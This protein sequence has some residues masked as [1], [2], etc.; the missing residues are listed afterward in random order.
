MIDLVKSRISAKWV[1]G[2]WVIGFG[3]ISALYPRDISYDVVHYQIHNGWSFLNDRS[4]VDF[5][6]AE[7]HSFLNPIWQVFVWFLI[8]S[9]P[10][11]DGFVLTGFDTG[12]D[13][14]R[15]ILFY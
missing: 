2:L 13:T 12:A 6:P 9:F 7:M 5:A 3:L 10:G 8:E 4:G 1:F 11:A 14:A 15:P